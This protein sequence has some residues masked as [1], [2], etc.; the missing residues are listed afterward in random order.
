[1]VNGREKFPICNVTISHLPMRLEWKLF[2][3]KYRNQPQRTREHEALSIMRVQIDEPISFE[4]AH[5]FDL[6]KCPGRPIDWNVRIA[7]L[8]QL[9]CAFGVLDAERIEKFSDDLALIQA[10]LPHFAGATF[11]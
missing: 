10:P 2:R 6:A 5:A 4:D 9:A 7:V 11:S 8:D 1:M 3:K